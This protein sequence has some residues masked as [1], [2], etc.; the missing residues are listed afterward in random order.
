M[1]STR[2][3]TKLK[4]SLDGNGMACSPLPAGSLRGSV[5]LIL[6]GVCTFEQKLN[7][8]QQA[9]ATA[10]LIYTDASRP[11]P[12]PMSAGG[13]TLPGEMISYNDGVAIKQSLSG[14]PSVTLDFSLRPSYTSPDG[15]AKEMTWRSDDD[16]LIDVYFN[17]NL[18][19]G[20]Y[21]YLFILDGVATFGCAI[22]ADFKQIDSYFDHSLAAARRLHDFNVPADARTGYSYGE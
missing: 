3:G 6:R 11:D 5:A 21:S 7:T 14:A 17:H 18:A 2:Q 19:P 20:G 13:S 1:R 4:A 8:A 9:G 16:E 22:V 10:A 12:I 15:L